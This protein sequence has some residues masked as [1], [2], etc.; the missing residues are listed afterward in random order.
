MKKTRCNC[1]NKKLL[2]EFK[3]KCEGMYCIDCLY[4][5]KHNCT[6]NYVEQ[7]KKELTN[8]LE[9]VVSEKITSF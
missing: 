1:C 6:F 2:M 7:Q 9:K 4:Q 8:K 5:E 3:C